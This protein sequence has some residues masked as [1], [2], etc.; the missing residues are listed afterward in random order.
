MALIAL[1]LFALCTAVSMALLSTGFGFTLGRGGVGR[2]FPTLAPVLGLASLAF[3]LCTPSAPYKSPL[4]I[5]RWPQTP[6]PMS[7][8]TPWTR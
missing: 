7:R 5:S 3:G 6:T 8:R 1:A 2:V 4:T